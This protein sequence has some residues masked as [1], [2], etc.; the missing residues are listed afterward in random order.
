MAGWMIRLG[1]THLVPLINLLSEQMLEQPLI[2]SDE[3]RLQVLRG[4]KAPTAD[5]WM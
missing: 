1:G 5:H 4:D 3:T 2:H